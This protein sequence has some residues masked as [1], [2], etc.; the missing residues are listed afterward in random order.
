MASQRG[1]APAAPA[2]RVLSTLPLGGA[3]GWDYLSFDAAHRHLFVSRGDR[4]LVIDVDS[5]KQI[6]TIANTPGVHGIAIAPDLHRG[7]TSNGKARSVTVFDL[8]Y[9]EDRRDDHRHR[10]EPGRDPLRQR[11]A[12]R[13]APSTATAHTPA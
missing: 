9:A 10:R 11:L 5:G 2:P 1:R 3:G 13:A 12:S 4:V 6:G 8:D 7:F